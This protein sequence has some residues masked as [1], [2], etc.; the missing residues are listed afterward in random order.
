VGS[1]PRR[2]DWLTVSHK[3]ALTPTDCCY[4]LISL[5]VTLLFAWL[6][7]VI[8]KS[9][10]PNQ[11]LYTYNVLREHQE[12]L[13]RMF[14]HV[15]CPEILLVTFTSPCHSS[16]KNMIK[17]FWDRT[18][19]NRTVEVH[20]RFGGEHYLHLHD[21]SQAER[22]IFC[23]FNAGR[24]LGL[25]LS[26]KDVDMFLRNRRFIFTGL[27]GVISEKTELFITTA[28]RL[29]SPAVYRPYY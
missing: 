25:I 1:T 2:T 24:L 13:N 4:S 19:Q 8:L 9:P 11:C 3:V 27:Y 26:S 6:P 20:W 14:R 17:I 18:E 15:G 5:H 28:L 10:S 7:Y 16:K 22:Y 29:E 23:L 12:W 21:R